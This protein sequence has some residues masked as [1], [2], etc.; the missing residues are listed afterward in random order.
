MKEILIHTFKHGAKVRASHHPKLSRKCSSLAEREKERE[1]EKTYRARHRHKKTDTETSK[2]PLRH[3][4]IENE[5]QAKSGSD[6]QVRRESAR[7]GQKHLQIHRFR[8]LKIQRKIQRQ[9]NIPPRHISKEIEREIQT[10]VQTYKQN[11]N[12]ILFFNYC[13]CKLSKYILPTM[14]KLHG[15]VQRRRL[16]SHYIIKHS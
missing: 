6:T 15:I 13:V 1:R 7:K 16:I 9:A 5:R 3:R 11:R 14:E 2:Q 4:G 8:H 12:I 10:A